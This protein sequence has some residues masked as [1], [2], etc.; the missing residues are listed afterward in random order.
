MANNFA[1]AQLFQ[2]NLDQLAIQEAVTGWMEANAGQVIYNGGNTVKVPKMSLSGMGD[3]SRANGYERGSVGLSYETFTF[4]QDRG[5]D[6]LIDSQDVDETNFVAS[7]STVL[8][9]YQRT[10][11]IPEIDAYRLSKA[12]ALA[13]AAGTNVAYGYTPD[14]T[15]ILAALKTAISNTKQAGFRNVPLICHITTEALTAV[16]LA[17]AGKLGAETFSQGGIDT[18]VPSLDGV[19]FIETDSERMVSAIETKSL[20]NGGGWAKAAGA[21]NVNFIVFPQTAPIAISKQNV[22]D[23]Y[24]PRQTQGADAWLIE[25]RRYHDLWVMDNKLPGIA[26]N[27]KDAK[28]AS[29][30]S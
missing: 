6:I 17:A 15:T 28:P 26:V 21:L 18:R 2:R 4:S 19:R 25:Y 22:I 12:A 13:M 7:A 1:Y 20:A 24:D 5:N 27:I 14:A 10:E 9:E 3:Y 30:S 8:G 29:T 16:E 23:I 11:V